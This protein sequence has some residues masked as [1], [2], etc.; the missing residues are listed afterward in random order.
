MIQ[1]FSPSELQMLIQGKESRVDTEDLRHHTVYKGYSDDSQTI[2]WFWEILHDM[3]EEDVQKLLQF[4]TS[5][6]YAPLLGFK[7][8]RPHFA[9][10]RVPCETEGERLP[11]AS[12][13]INL[14]KLP[15]YST[16]EMM[17]EKLMYSI[18]SNAGFDLS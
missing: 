7:Y 9:I 5:S 8:L 15:D 11:T 4:V 13:C 18:H 12:T 6:P 2:Q 14:L 1:M 10:H 3:E 16:K 17:R